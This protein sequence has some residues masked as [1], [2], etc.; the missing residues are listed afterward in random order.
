LSIS[1]HGQMYYSISHLLVGKYFINQF[2]SAI[3]LHP[4]YSTL[5]NVI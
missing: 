1:N 4:Y 3:L 2:P 5:K